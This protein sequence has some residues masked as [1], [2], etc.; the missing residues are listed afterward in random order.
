MVYQEDN[1][2]VLYADEL[3]KPRKCNFF[4][5]HWSWQSGLW[6]AAN[7]RLNLLYHGEKDKRYLEYRWSLLISPIQLQVS[8]SHKLT[9]DPANAASSLIRC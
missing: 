2:I 8:H 5:A 4:S 3:T 1:I 6:S 9:D 7:W